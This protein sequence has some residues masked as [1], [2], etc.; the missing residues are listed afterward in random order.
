M[1]ITHKKLEEQRAI[2]T[3]NPVGWKNFVLMHES[4]GFENYSR[5]QL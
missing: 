3:Q 5:G 1:K 4:E 2:C